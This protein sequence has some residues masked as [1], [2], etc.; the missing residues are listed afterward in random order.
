MHIKH[1]MVNN[2]E[3]FKNYKKVKKY[4]ENENEEKNNKVN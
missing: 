2:F 3:I 1:I 4:Y